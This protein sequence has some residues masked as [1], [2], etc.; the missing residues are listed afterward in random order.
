[1]HITFHFPNAA[2]FS[3]PAPDKQLNEE[4]LI[5]TDLASFFTAATFLWH[6]I[7]SLLNIKDFNRNIYKKLYCKYCCG[8]NHWNANTLEFSINKAFSKPQFK[9]I[10]A[11]SA[12]IYLTQLTRMVKKINT[13]KA[14]VHGP[15]P[16]VDN[17]IIFMI[18][19]NRL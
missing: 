16:M 7:N 1:M 12:L 2:L 19:T 18:N 3:S 4:I 6:E 17:P 9:I 15:A 14:L 5:P 11:S 13:H 10:Y 8:T